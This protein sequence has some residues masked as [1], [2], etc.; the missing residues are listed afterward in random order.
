MP[1]SCLAIQSPRVGTRISRLGFPG[2]KI[3]NRG[4]RRGHFRGVLIRL[5]EDVLDFSPRAIVLLIGTNDFEEK[6]EP[7]T[8]VANVKLILAELPSLMR[9]CRSSFARCS[10]VSA[11]KSRPSEKIKK[12]NQ[13][14][15]ASVKGNTQV[16]L[17]ETWTLFADPS[18]DATAAQFPDLLHVNLAGYAK[19]AAALRPLFATLGL[20][21]NRALRIAP[22]NPAFVISSMARP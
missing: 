3:A 20:F 15:A 13:L 9:T 21:G 12:V 7:E 16:T 5:K 6:A 14:Y 18:G 17:L 10:R 4:I 22:R 1:S 19:W 8:I 2:I 11:S